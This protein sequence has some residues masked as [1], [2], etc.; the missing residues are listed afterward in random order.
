[1]APSSGLTIQVKPSVSAKRKRGTT[2]KSN[3]SDDKNDTS[4]PMK[5]R[6]TANSATANNY[7]SV[8]LS[9]EAKMQML[10]CSRRD[11][12]RILQRGPG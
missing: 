12:Q 6:K 4:R 10:V 8:G 5:A 1:M 3:N 9:K 11:G 7:S 2:C